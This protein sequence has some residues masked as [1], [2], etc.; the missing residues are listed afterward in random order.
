MPLLLLPVPREP[1]V[2]GILPVKLQGDMPGAVPAGFV[3]RPL[4]GWREFM[5][6]A[7]PPRGAVGLALFAAG[8]EGRDPCDGMPGDALCAGGELA[9][10]AAIASPA[11]NASMAP[12]E[13]NIFIFMAVSFLEVT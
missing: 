8:A 5:V 2:S 12:A 1:V 6:G 9:G 11:I 3:L 13:T 7:L 4:D 10:T